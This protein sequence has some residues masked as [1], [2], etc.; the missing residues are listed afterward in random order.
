[1]SS[2][3]KSR[4]IKF[5][6]GCSASKAI[7]IFLV[8]LSWLILFFV[9]E[10]CFSAS[11]EKD[12]LTFPSPKT[13]TITSSMLLDVVNT[14]NRLV[15]VGEWGLVAYSDDSGITW[16]QATV[17]T[18]VTLTAV[19]FPTTTKG[20]AVGHDGVILH[21]DNSG[22]TWVKQLDGAI[23]ASAVVKQMEALYKAKK[24]EVEAAGENR[25]DELELELEDLK[26]L[27]EDARLVLTEGP[28]TPFL[29][30]WFKNDR[31][32][33]VVGGFGL[34]FSTK[35]G[36]MTWEPNLDRIEN[37]QGLHYY[38]ITRAG[39]TL[40]IAGE[41][42]I[43]FRSEDEGLSWEPINSPYEGSFFGVEGATNGGFVI[44]YGLLGNAF[45]ST[46]MGETWQPINTPKGVSLG[47][48]AVFPHGEIALIG[49]SGLFLFSQDVGESFHFEKT[50]CRGCTGVAQTAGGDFVLVGR[51]GIVRLSLSDKLE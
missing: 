48:A 46:D 43:L 40:F 50:A 47:G 23:F 42:G 36:G 25:R 16:H 29:D 44:V 14:G 26:Y 20:W 49:Y 1:M 37:P 11:V 39:G 8:P 38:G 32:G 15:A 34:I 28:T 51:E 6:A 35:D 17:P 2:Y 4:K 19:C 41:S 27:L 12:L 13:P 30:V 7:F 45:R 3:K 5:F 9:V 22:S 33:I 10:P 31:E 18:S 21:S 24:A